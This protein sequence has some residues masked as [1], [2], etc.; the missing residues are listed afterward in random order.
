MVLQA[1]FEQGVAL[2]QQERLADAERIYLEVLQQQPNHFDALHLLG[3][4]SLQTGRT[5][6]AVELIGKAIGLNAAVPAVHSNLGN[7]LKNL[8]RPADAL[9][10]YDKAIALKPDYAEAHYNRG[11]LLLELARPADALKSYNQVIALRPDDAEAWRPR[12][13]SA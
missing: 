5:E 8:R 7:A 11:N 3:I 10:S 4:I 2:H 12:A 13:S 1:K 6:R 9:A